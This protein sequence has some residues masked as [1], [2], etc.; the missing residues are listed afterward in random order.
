MGATSRAKTSLERCGERGIRTPGTFRHTRFPVVHLRPLGHLSSCPR[1]A[2]HVAQA[3][4]GGHGIRTRG[5]LAGTPDFESGALNHSANPPPRGLVWA[6]SDVK[7]FGALLG[8]QAPRNARESGVE[9]RGV[10][11]AVQ[12][13]PQSRSISARTSDVPA[14]MGRDASRQPLWRAKSHALLRH[15]HPSRSRFQGGIRIS[16]RSGLRNDGKAWRPPSHRA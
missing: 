7:S 1:A 14:V 10:G 13:V 8:K 9:A 5:T 12:D 2:S 15:P 6:G 16:D 4:G 3:P 11:G